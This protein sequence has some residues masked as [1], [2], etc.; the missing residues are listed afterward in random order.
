MWQ[1]QLYFGDNRAQ[2]LG[3]SPAQLAHEAVR[4]SRL[5]S[6]QPDP[7]AELWEADTDT[8]DWH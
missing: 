3:I 7:E 6:S 2:R 5:I 8:A 4:Q 1:N